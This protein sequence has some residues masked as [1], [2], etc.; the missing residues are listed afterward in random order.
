M[1]RERVRPQGRHLWGLALPH[2]PS[3]IHSQ[4]RC[5]VPLNYDQSALQVTTVNWLEWHKKGHGAVLGLRVPSG[6]FQL[7]APAF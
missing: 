7:N 2:L 1:K 4:S 5:F 3:D 6:P